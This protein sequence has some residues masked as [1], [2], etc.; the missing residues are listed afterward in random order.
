MTNLRRGMMAAGSS[1]TP[2]WYRFY[3]TAPASRIET[4]E[5]NF[6]VNSVSQPTANMTDYNAPSPYITSSSTQDAGLTWY[7]FSTDEGDWGSANTQPPH[8]I[9]IY[10]GDYE[11][12]ITLS[13]Y[14]YQAS[15]SAS[16]CPTAWVLTQSSTGDFSGEETTVDTQSGLSWSAAETKTFNL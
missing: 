15:Y 11:V 4:Q 10:L 9:R 3:I 5:I 1:I 2:L 13:S 6:V 7:A 8:W 16:R 14:T 12:P